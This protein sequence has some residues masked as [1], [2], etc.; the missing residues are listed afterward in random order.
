MGPVKI[1]RFSLSRDTI[2]AH[3]IASITIDPRNPR[4]KTHLAGYRRQERYPEAGISNMK[5]TT[6]AQPIR[7]GT[8]NPPKCVDGHHRDKRG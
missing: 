5:T 1:S 8:P 3:R 6:T 2:V 7:N 4:A